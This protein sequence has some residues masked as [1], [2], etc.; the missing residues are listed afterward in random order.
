MIRLFMSVACT[1]ILSVSTASQSRATDLLSDIEFIQA[2]MNYAQ[3]IRW[4]GAGSALIGLTGAA[5]GGY[6]H[7][8]RKRIGH[9]PVSTNMTESLLSHG[10][11]L[12]LVGATAYLIFRG[13]SSSLKS[14]SLYSLFKQP[15]DYILSAAQNDPHLADL[16]QQIAF[17]LRELE[18]LREKAH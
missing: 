6:W 3:P 18:Q 12:M 8:M 7:L 2:Q 4:F 11:L 14:S 1:F 16:I 17:R 10:V 13:N 15:A 9:Y 5:G